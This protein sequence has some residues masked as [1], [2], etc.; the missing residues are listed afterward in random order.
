[1]NTE[2]AVILEGNIGLANEKLALMIRKDGEICYLDQIK[3]DDR[4]LFYINI[5]MNKQY[6]IYNFVIGTVNKGKTPL[7]FS[8][9]VDLFE[10]SISKDGNIVDDFSNIRGGDELKINLKKNNPSNDTDMLIAAQYG[11]GGRLE[12][13]DSFENITTT[14]LKIKIKNDDV[15]S[16]KLLLWNSEEMKPLNNAYEVQ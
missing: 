5:P 13:V 6:G 16:V 9:D 1:M 14:E 11:A 3:S 10:M 4:G 15:S 12:A 8:F 2:S 7:D